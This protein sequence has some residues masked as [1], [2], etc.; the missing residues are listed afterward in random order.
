MDDLNK[1]TDRR[2][3]LK[4]AATGTAILLMPS[5][6]QA[7]D[8]QP[9]MG[10]VPPGDGDIQMGPRFV[11]TTGDDKRA[12]KGDIRLPSS[13]DKA[14]R[15]AV[16]V[17]RDSTGNVI[18]QYGVNAVTCGSGATAIAMTKGAKPANPVQ[19]S[20]KTTFTLNLQVEIDGAGSVSV[21]VP[22]GNPE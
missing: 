18:V 12:G 7:R 5:I 21:I 9:P 13:T 22:G 14:A 19:A 2:E 8:D 3:L 11:T 4:A 15:F 10:D 20:G 17:S 16:D 1:K 6:A